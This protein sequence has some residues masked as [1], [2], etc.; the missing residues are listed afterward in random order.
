MKDEP[1]QYS[2]AMGDK[3]YSC[4]LIPY[5]QE[6]LYPSA[7]GVYLVVRLG[8]GPQDISVICLFTCFSEGLPSEKLHNSQITSR[9]PTHLLSIQSP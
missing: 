9:N 8:K 3:A 1:E 2:L 6:I 7:A 5:G 4:D